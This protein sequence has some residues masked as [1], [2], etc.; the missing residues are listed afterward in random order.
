MEFI[1]KDEIVKAANACDSQLR[2]SALAIMTE[3]VGNF[4]EECLHKA[5]I[6]GTYSGLYYK[7][8][9][10]HSYFRE[11]NADYSFPEELKKALEEA[12]YKVQHDGK[13]QEFRIS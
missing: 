13:S 4:L 2:A 3:E 12:G 7:D 6:D 10:I 5:K 8:F 9:K 11:S 1:K